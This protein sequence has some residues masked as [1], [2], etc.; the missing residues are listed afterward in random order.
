MGKEAEDLLASL[1]LSDADL[2]DY[3]TVKR[4]FEGHFIPCTN[5]IF[6]RAKFNRRKQEANESVESFITDLHNLA[7]TC[8]YGSLKDDLIRDRLVVGLL[9]LGLSEKLLLDS[10]LTLQSAV[11]IARNSEFVK[12]QQNEQ[13]DATERGASVDELRRSKERRN[14]GGAQRK[15]VKPPAV[16]FTGRNL[17]KWCGSTQQHFKKQCPAFG[18]LCNNCGKTGHYAKVCLSGRQQPIGQR[19]FGS[20]TKKSRTANTEEVFLGEVSETDTQE[21]WFII[22][23]VNSRPVRF[24]VVTGAD[25]S[26]IPASQYD[27]SRM[28]TLKTPDKR[29]VGPGRTPITTK[30]MFSATIAWQGKSVQQRVFVV[31]GLQTALLGRPAI[32]A[33]DIRSHLEAV[34]A[35]KQTEARHMVSPEARPEFS[36]LFTGLGKMKTPYKVTLKAN[37]TPYAV[38]TPRR[39]AVPLQPKVEQELQRMKDLGVIQQ[40]YHATPWCAPMVIASK[41]NGEIRICIDYTELN[42]Q[43]MRE[44]VIMPTVEENLA[45][46][47]NA[48]VFSKLDANSGYWQ[49]P[50]APESQDLTTFITLFGRFQ[51]LRLPFGIATAPEFFQLRILEGL[52]GIACHQD[53]VVVFGKNEA[54][55]NA[56]LTAVLQRLKGAGMTLN[57]RKC[58]FSKRRVKFLGHILNEAGIAADQEKTEA[59]RKM[60]PP[61]NTTELRSFLGMV[62]QLAKF[63]PGLAE[64]TKPLRDLLL[65]EAVWVWHQT[66]QEAFDRVKDDLTTTPVLCYYDPQRPLTIS[67]DASSYGLGAVLLQTNDGKRQPVAY[68]SRAMTPTEQKYA[69]VEKE[70]LSI[71]WACERFRMYVLG[72]QF[73]IETDH[74][75]LVPLFSTKR[76]DEMTPRLQRFRMRVLA[77][78]FT[79]SHI[80]GKDMHTDDI[81]SR[82]PL[83]CSGKHLASVIEE[84]ELL[85]IEQLP[86]STEM[87][88]RTKIELQKDA[89]TSLVMHYCTTK[90]PKAEMLAPEVRKYA[91]VPDEL[92][93]VQ[94]LLLRG[95]RIVFPPSL[96]KE[97]L[98][99]LHT[100]HQGVVRC[101]ARARE[102]SW[103]PAISQDVETY[104]RRCPTCTK[105]RPVANEDLLQTP[106]PERPWQVVGTHL[107]HHEGRNYIV[108]V[109]YYS[110]FFELEELCGTQ[111]KHVVQFLSNLFARYGIPDILRSDNGPQYS[112]LEFLQFMS[113]WGVRHVTSSP[114][115]AQSNGEAERAVQTAKNIIRESTNVA[116]GLLAHRA[117]PGPEGYSPAELL[118]GRKLKTNVPTLPETLEPKWEY[119][120]QFRQNNA[121]IRGREAKLYNR[122]RKTRDRPPLKPGTVFRTNNKEP[123]LESQTHRDLMLC[124][125]PKE[126]FVA[127]KHICKRFP[128]CTTETS[129]NGLF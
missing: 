35:N 16:H 5:V 126:A 3:A 33:L 104:V 88:N 20:S 26:V 92:S 90:W 32:R 46:L 76:I 78:D 56:N 100:G 109:D 41:Q 43:L 113:S 42:R 110:R 87:L 61:E 124:K 73:S 121:V 36:Q 84:Y 118:M 69:Q 2:A 12:K 94:G 48:K 14:H 66:Q 102:S 8:E 127:Q 99:R 71:T 74:K 10:K 55:H 64:K 77:Y 89:T 63:L 108:A 19:V 38:T 1:S 106:L 68:A 86:A 115:Y 83:Q 45:K 105:H 117:T 119:Q 13:R 62:N 7:D 4:K 37:A 29:L 18:K 39:V 15:P 31:E 25:V 28:Q 60:P 57:P 67:A 22:A 98:Q 30:G 54:E 107:L 49:T 85:T 9:D 11:K 24:K 44:R 53:D 116:E 123:S 101:R 114:H 82:K 6:E 40:V 93:V 97:V 128:N 81:L 79:I 120:N 65:D 21:P 52:P 129:R 59:I 80:P 70:A 27:S 50:L 103:W 96:R 58:E 111:T 112:S 95:T 122:R 51:F 23:L 47:A 125:R 75:P 17:C 72:L 34:E 91:S